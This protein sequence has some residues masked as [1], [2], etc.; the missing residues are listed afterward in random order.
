LTTHG[1][2][3]TASVRAFATPAASIT[4]F[5]KSFDPSMRAAAEAVQAGREKAV[6]GRAL[7]L[8]Q[9]SLSGDLAYIDD[10]SSTSLPPA[11]QDV[12]KPQSSGAVHQAS[13]QLIQPIYN[14]KAAADKDQMQKQT[15]LA[16]IRFV[17]ARQDL[18]QKVGEA[19]FGVLLA[20][21]VLH[22]TQAEKAAVAMQRDRAKARFDVGRGKITDVQETQARYDSVVTKEIS[23]QSTLALREAQYLELTGAPDVALTGLRADFLPQPPQPDD[24]SA[25]QSKGRTLNTQVQ[26]K[27]AELVIA[28]AEIRK[29]T[30]DARPTLDFVASYTYKGQN[31]SLSPTI[32]PD[33][34]RMAAIGVQLSVPLYTGGAINSKQRESMAKQRQAEAELGAAQRDARLSVQDAWLAVKTGVARIGSLEQSVLSAK[35]ALEGTTLGRD[36]GTRIDLD[37]LDAQQRLFSAQLDLAQARNDYLLGR[38]RLARATGELQ[39]SDLR[40]LNA[41]LASGAATTGRLA[42][43]SVSSAA[44][45]GQP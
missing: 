24:L 42:L 21:E 45:G 13:L 35:T 43:S 15:D 4:S 25:W 17:S 12:I 19:Y 2:R 33:N 8:P 36:V 18:I 44:R 5:A 20:R 27:Q 22:V 29:Y 10:K 31:G 6:Q 32:S 39:E 26:V 14:A 30:L 16:E 9:V 11:L 40:E 3:A 7:L 34:N 1:G 41:Y 38:I 28:G 37:V 23:A